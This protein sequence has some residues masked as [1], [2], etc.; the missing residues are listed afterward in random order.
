MRIDLLALLLTLGCGVG[1]RGRSAEAL[2][3]GLAPLPPSIDGA[4]RLAAR[5]CT[6]CHTIDRVLLTRVESP[7]HWRYYVDRMRR[8][9]GSGISPE[10]GQVIVRCLVYRSFGGAGLQA[11]DAESE[12]TR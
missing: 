1:G 8:Q 3:S 2:V 7:E 10:D 5:R 11:L 12:A 4:C 9:P 6:R